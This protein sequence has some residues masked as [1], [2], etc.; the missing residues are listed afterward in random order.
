MSDERKKKKRE[1]GYRGLSVA[2]RSTVETG[3]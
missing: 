1:E 3:V 2:G